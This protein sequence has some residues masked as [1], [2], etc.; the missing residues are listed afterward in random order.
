MYNRNNGYGSY[1]DEPARDY[2]QYPKRPT[3]ITVVCILI[4][5][6]LVITLT[7]NLQNQLL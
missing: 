5:M 2:T 7:Q 3:S 6:A 1:N 4:T